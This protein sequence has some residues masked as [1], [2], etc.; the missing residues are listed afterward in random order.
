LDNVKPLSSIKRQD[1]KALGPERDEIRALPY[2]SIR[3]TSFILG[4]CD[5]SYSQESK[6]LGKRVRNRKKST[7]QP[8]ER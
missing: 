7:Q 3:Q 5:G 1:E 6:A 4:R 2:T 8:K